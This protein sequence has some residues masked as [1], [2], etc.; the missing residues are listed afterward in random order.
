MW[1]VKGASILLVDVQPPLLFEIA[2]PLFAFGVVGLS[3]R[4]GELKGPLGTAGVVVAYLAAASAVVAFLTE[5]S[6]FIAI[7][8][9]GPFLGLVLVGSAMLQAH[10]FSSPWSALPLAMGLGGPLLIL[11]GGGLALINER[12][13]EVPIVIVGLA[14][15]LLGYMVLAGTAPLRPRARVR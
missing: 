4:L 10:A 3:A 5:L 1:I 7:A 8:G 6:V 2:I 9:F 11:A 15:V 14:W 12:L 13:L